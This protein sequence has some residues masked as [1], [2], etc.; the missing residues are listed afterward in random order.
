[1]QANNTYPR[2]HSSSWASL[3]RSFNEG[4]EHGPPS[5]YV[6][7][8]RAITS[9]TDTKKQNYALIDSGATHHFCFD[10][11]LFTN[12]E[13]ISP[14]TVESATGPSKVI[15]VGNILIPIYVGRIARAYHAP[16]FETHI[17][18]VSQLDEHVDIKF[19]RRS[20]SRSCL[21]FKPGADILV[22]ERRNQDGLYKMKIANPQ[23]MRTF[24]N[25]LEVNP[26]KAKNWHD[27]S[28]HLS[29]DRYLKLRNFEESILKFSRE[30]L[31]SI[32]CAP[33]IPSKSWRAPAHRAI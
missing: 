3:G 29:T 28:G 7:L 16:D 15:G 18:S 32:T 10:R 6:A 25:Q 9:K 33:C 21:I 24:A 11:E 20:Q 30:I 12:Y 1:M 17:L 31:D 14:K 5:A 22:F 2:S 23:K 8:M 4:H 19:K 13:V 26:T 27:K